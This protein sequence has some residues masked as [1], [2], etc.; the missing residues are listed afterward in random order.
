MFQRTHRDTT[1]YPLGVSAVRAAMRAEPSGSAQCRRVA[2]LVVGGTEELP[3]ATS[4]SG[5]AVRVQAV[6]LR[7]AARQ[8][9]RLRAEAAAHGRQSSTVLVDIEVLVAE[10]ARV[11]RTMC[12]ELEPSLREPHRPKSLT[13]IGTS[14]GLAGLIADIC[15]LRIADGVALV[16][17]GKTAMS[18]RIFD[19][20]LLQ[21]TSMGFVVDTA[22]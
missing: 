21:L 9:A 15:M 14:R 20:V 1:Y 8:S 5:P 16:P 19:D 12:A 3:S 4:D 22:G 7:D 13:Y 18:D 10:T 2:V 6:D 11:A 17:L